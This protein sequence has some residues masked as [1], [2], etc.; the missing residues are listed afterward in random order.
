MNL[1]KCIDDLRKSSNKPK[2]FGE[3]NKK[4]NDRFSIS[5][6]I[7]IGSIQDIKIGFDNHR[8]HSRPH[9]HIELKKIGRVSIAI[10][11]GSV[12]AP[13]KPKISN[14]TLSKIKDWLIPKKECLKFIYQNINNCKRKE[15]FEPIIDAFNRYL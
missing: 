7:D 1:N 12:L 13:K 10:D 5:F 8:N 11:N 4:I 2:K 9:I 3:L 6:I 15:D 14:Q